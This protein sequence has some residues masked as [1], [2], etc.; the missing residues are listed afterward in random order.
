MVLTG[1]AIIGFALM[2]G[3]RCDKSPI[4]D[5]FIGKMAIGYAARLNMYLKQRQSKYII[6]LALKMRYETMTFKDVS[7]AYCRLYNRSL[8]DDVKQALSKE[9]YTTFKSY[10]I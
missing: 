2:A 3:K 1:I 9:E 5:P 7:K 10:I 6:N 4:P 8:G